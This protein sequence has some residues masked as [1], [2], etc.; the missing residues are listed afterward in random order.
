MS[1]ESNNEKLEYSQVSES[2][3][4]YLVIRYMSAVYA[5][6]KVRF[7]LPGGI[8]DKSVLNVE[9]KDPFLNGKLRPEAQAAAVEKVLSEVKRTNFRMCLVINVNEGIYCEADGSTNIT[10]PPSGG[11]GV[12]VMELKQEKLTH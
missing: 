3:F 11:I 1:N 6:Q 8:H 7:I 12:G 10:V 5:R 4:P 9:F 2:E